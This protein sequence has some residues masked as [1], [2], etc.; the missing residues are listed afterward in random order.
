[1]AHVYFSPI[2]SYS[3]TPQIQSSARQLLETVIANEGITLEPYVPLKVHFG[4]KGNTTFIA[5]QNYEGIIAS[6]QEQQV[7]SAFI[8]TNVLYRGSRTTR[9]QHLKLAAEH[10]FTQLP[11]VIADG[12]HGDEY[13]E[14]AINQKHFTTCKIGKEI[15]AQRQM[16]VISHFKGHGLAG[17]GG[18]LKQL[19]MGCA[20]RGGKLAQH[21]D[22]RP[23]INPLA[24]KKCGTCVQHCPVNAIRLGWLPHIEKAACTGCAS[25]IAVCPHKAIVF[26]PLRLSFAKKFY[27]KI[28]ESALA[29]QYHHT[30]NIYLN[31]AFNLT[32][33]CDCEGKFMRPIARDVGILASTDPVAIDRASLDL[34]AQREGKP[35]FGRGHHILDYAEQIGLGRTA[36]T[37]VEI[38]PSGGRAA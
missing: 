20:A 16:I 21:A 4:E 35:V 29:A 26:N 14:V 33:G 37:F 34:I 22:A 9:T 24:C 17:F 2:E 28:A 7:E 12:E 6:L 3:N 25:C 8:E 38:E 36:Y 11:V 27:E 23:L 5:S 31:F 1:M 32:K 13:E 10:G 19:G 30:N 15:A 18:A